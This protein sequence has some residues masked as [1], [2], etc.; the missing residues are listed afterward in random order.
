[1]VKRVIE[2]K[3]REL[4]TQII[5]KAYVFPI[6]EEGE[7][8]QAVEVRALWDTGATHCLITP[9]LA[10]RMG[11]KSLGK[12]DNNTAGGIVEGNVYQL[13]LYVN[14]HIVYPRLYFGEAN[15]GG[16]F[17]IVIGMNAIRHGRFTIEGHGDDRKFT[18]ELT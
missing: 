14:E 12:K 3:G 2:I 11:M 7:L 13:G 15:G 5:S 6:V 1:M 8:S 9:E 18:F 16:R 17:D 4:L 10:E